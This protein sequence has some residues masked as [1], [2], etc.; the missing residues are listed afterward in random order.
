MWAA[1]VCLRCLTLL[2]N[3]TRL[4]FLTRRMRVCERCKKIINPG[5]RFAWSREVLAESN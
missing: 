3:E 4:S 1:S 5:E 2:K